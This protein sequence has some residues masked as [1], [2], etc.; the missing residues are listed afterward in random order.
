MPVSR[1]LE[2]VVAFLLCVVA[3]AN[4]ALAGAGGADV[5]VHSLMSI[6][7]LQVILLVVVLFLV[8]WAIILLRRAAK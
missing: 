8:I 3:L 6:A 1:Y 2:C 5:G 7:I 4:P